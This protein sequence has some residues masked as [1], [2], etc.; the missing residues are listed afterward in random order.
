[1]IKSVF[2]RSSVLLVS[3]LFALSMLSSC[4][5]KCE[6]TEVE[7]K[8]KECKAKSATSTSNSGS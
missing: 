5:V 7:V 3:S 4:G 8:G 1:M 6:G 2:R